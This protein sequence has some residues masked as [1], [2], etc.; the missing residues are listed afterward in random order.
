[1]F[2]E[3]SSSEQFLHRAFCCVPGLPANPGY[4]DCRY[5]NANG[6]GWNLIACNQ[7]PKEVHFYLESS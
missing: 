2:T 1:M 3:S 4:T 7:L 6:Q 5:A